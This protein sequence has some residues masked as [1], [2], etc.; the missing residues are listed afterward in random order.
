MST[1]LVI[2]AAGKGTR[3]GSEKLF[4]HLVDKTLLEWNLELAKDIVGLS[5]VIVVAP[6]QQLARIRSFARAYPSLSVKAI[7]GGDKRL[8]SSYIGVSACRGEFILL[9]NV[10]NPLAAVDDF[11]RLIHALEKEDCACFVGQPVVDTLRRAKNGQV[12]L[13]DRDW[14]YRAQTPQGFR[15]KTLLKLM[16]ENLNRDV[17]DEVT[18]YERT[19]LKIRAFPCALV[20]LKITFPEDLDFLQQYL[21]NEYLVGIGEDSHA[22]GKDG[23]LVLGAVRVKKHPKLQANSDGDV[24]LHAL[25]NAIGS[26]LGGASIS[27][28][29]D[30]M[31]EAGVTD[32]K[33]YLR[34]VLRNMFESGR[35]LSNVA[36]SLECKRPKI[37]PL[38]DDMKKQLSQLLRVHP[39]R[40]GITATSGEELSSFG[41]G[42]GIH[43]SCVVSLK[44]THPERRH[45][46]LHSHQRHERNHPVEVSG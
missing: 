32:S 27:Q 13:V 18:L 43:C 17:T 41:R 33:E 11:D 24:I 4:L 31:C 29:A 30:E 28:T 3:F 42:E 15:R 9:H 10:A 2:L 20:N 5:E 40:I 36:V 19:N 44:S 39:S 45:Q 1:S 6:Q 12:T 14:L 21:G 46:S 34:V 35:E 23:E 16:R 22:F 7:A 25:V 37:D 26:A 8:D 38:V